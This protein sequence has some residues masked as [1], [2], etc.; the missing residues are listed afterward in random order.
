M[1]SQ[2][3]GGRL[4]SFS[5]KPLLWGA[6]Q[7]TKSRPRPSAG[8]SAPVNHQVLVPGPNAKYFVQIF[9]MTSLPLEFHWWIDYF[10]MTLMVIINNRAEESASV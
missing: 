1:V 6:S 2:A 7:P 10:T 4:G 9:L 5:F 8:A 3:R